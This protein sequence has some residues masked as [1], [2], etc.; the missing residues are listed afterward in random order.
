MNDLHQNGGMGEAAIAAMDRFLAARRDGNPQ[1]ML[2][3]TSADIVYLMHGRIAG[4]PIL[5]AIHGRDALT[6]YIPGLLMRWSW[7]EMKRVTRL[8][9]PNNAG[10]WSVMTEHEGI[11]RHNV[12]G[13]RFDLET[14]EIADFVEGRMIRFRGY[15]DTLTVMRVAGL[16]M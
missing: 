16:A 3:E 15:T 14:C 4:Q 12:T 10:G 9:A 5:P 8:A 1:G 2:A 13:Q 6:I 7:C 11:M